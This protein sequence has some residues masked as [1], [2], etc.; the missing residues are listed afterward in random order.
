MRNAKQ[1]YSYI[2][3]VIIALM[4]GCILYLMFHVEPAVGQIF[5]DEEIALHMQCHDRNGLF[6]RAF[7]KGREWVSCYQGK[8]KLWSVK[9]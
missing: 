4:G 2:G 9:L 8:K 5:S 1:R 6:A 7:D 3:L